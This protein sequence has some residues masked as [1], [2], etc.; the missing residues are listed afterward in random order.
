MSYAFR[1]GLTSAALLCAILLA[2]SGSE[3]LAGLGTG[4]AIGAVIIQIEY[5]ATFLWRRRRS[6]PAQHHRAHS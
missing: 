6:A 5:I 1:L 4:L 2:R 3:L